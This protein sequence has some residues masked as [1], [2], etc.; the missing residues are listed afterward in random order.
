MAIEDTPPPGDRRRSNRE[1]VTHDL[2][3]MDKSAPSISPLPTAPL[4]RPV[5]AIFRRH[6][7][8]QWHVIARPEVVIGRHEG[9]DI[10]LDDDSVSRRHARIIHQNIDHPGERPR[11]LIEDTGSRNGTF[12]NGRRITVATP[13]VSGDRI[14]CGAMC[15]IYSVRTEQEI[16]SD[17]RLLAMATTDALTGLMNRGHMAI[18]YAREVERARRYMRP[19]SLVLFDLDDFKKVN[20]G[21]GHDV[22]DEVLRQVGRILQHQ[23]RAHDLA[24][25]YGGEEFTVL[26]PETPLAGAM[27]IAERLRRAIASAPVATRDTLLRVTGSFGVAAFIHGSDRTF[28]DLVARADVALLEA[29]K[30]GK[31]RVVSR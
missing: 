11:C 23:C 30:Q 9:V 15:L 17:L 14:F 7:L 18:Q 5:L 10:D 19:V 25:R 26:L 29:K 13:L 12:V 6:E 4:T 24:A 3:D 21:H 31:D 28:E 22:G 27:V 20:D 1:D 2:S 16:T 8:S